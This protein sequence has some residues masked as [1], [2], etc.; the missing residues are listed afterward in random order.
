MSN[1]SI[2][3]LHNLIKN[4]KTRE[5]INFSS[6]NFTDIKNAPALDLTATDWDLPTGGQTAVF[7]NYTGSN[8]HTYK[9]TIS[10][11]DI[12][13]ATAV[14]GETYTHTYHLTDGGAVDQK[15]TFVAPNTIFFEDETSNYIYLN[16]NF[17]IYVDN[18]L[19]KIQEYDGSNWITKLNLD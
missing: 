1:K 14:S 3:R 7:T 8:N 5:L 11:G 19:F 16:D 17:R 4:T 10:N 13:Y 6:A 9:I 12:R 2:R 15:M 18:T